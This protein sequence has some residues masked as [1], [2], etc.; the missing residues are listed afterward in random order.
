M[1]DILTHI[2]KRITM[3]ELKNYMRDLNYVGLLAMR[4]TLKMN[5]HQPTLIIAIY[6]LVSLFFRLDQVMKRYS[7]NVPKLL[8][9]FSLGQKIKLFSKMSFYII[10]I[11]LV[12]MNFIMQIQTYFT[13]N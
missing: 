13:I 9:K 4:D 6:L 11:T 12:A 8:T 3:R 10:G 5:H 2:K 7:D 1:Y